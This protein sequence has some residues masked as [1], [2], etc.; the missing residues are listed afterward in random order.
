MTAALA[1]EHLSLLAAPPPEFV[2]AAAEAGFGSVGLRVA[3]PDGGTPPWNMRVGSP[4]MR[5]TRR[6]L[7]DTGT[8]VLGIEVIGITGDLDR[9]DYAPSLETGAELG[10]R[11]LNVAVWD[12]VPARRRASIAELTEEAARYGLVPQVEFMPYS[13]VRTVQDAVDAVGDSAAGIQIDTLHLARSGGRASDVAALDRDRLAYLQISDAP[14][15]APAT[16]DRLREEARR[17]RLAPGHGELDLAEVVGLF[18]GSPIAVEVPM[19]VQAID[20]GATEFLRMLH[21]A[22]GELVGEAAERMARAT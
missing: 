9:S 4:L 12:P 14:K 2:R 18:A 21:R 7:A 5:R 11:Y 20:L 16:I 10:A 15:S 22:T 1:V 6:A 8:E 17:G 13:A 3:S 19:P